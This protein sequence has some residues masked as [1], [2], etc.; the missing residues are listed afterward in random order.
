[1]DLVKKEYHE[2]LERTC[3]FEQALVHMQFEG[4]PSLGKNIREMQEALH[5]FD[6]QIKRHTQEQERMIF[7]YLKS[8]IPRLASIIFVLR[9]EHR[10]FKMALISFKSQWRIFLKNKNGQKRG[11]LAKDLKE[12]GMYLMYLLQGHLA[13][14]NGLLYPAAERELRRDEK[15]ELMRKMKAL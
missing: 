5:F 7:P 8:H 4:K 10:D 12:K 6:H 3:H 11:R 1:V 13:G 2:T 9:T 15:I 14:E